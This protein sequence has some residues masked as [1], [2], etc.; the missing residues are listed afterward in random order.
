MEIFVNGQA[1]QMAGELSVAQLLAEMGVAQQRLAVELNREIVPRSA[2]GAQQLKPGD[3][4]EMI[5]AV[6]GG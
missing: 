6:G 4:L 1:R 3:C 5:R 2:Y